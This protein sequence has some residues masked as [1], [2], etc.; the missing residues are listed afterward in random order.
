MHTRCIF[1]VRNRTISNQ[2]GDYTVKL[3]QNKIK[4]MVLIWFNIFWYYF[5]SNL[6]TSKRKWMK[7]NQWSKSYLTSSQTWN[8]TKEIKNLRKNIQ[9]LSKETKSNHDTLKVRLSPSKK[10]FFICFN[11][12][13]SK[14]MKNAVYFIL[15]ALFV[16]KIFEFLS[17]L[18]GHVEK[19]LD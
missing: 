11:D 3:K 9:T 19:W 17:W 12:S 6:N 16:L 4:N 5:T 14:I 8:I 1:R 2:N 15:K 7:T 10:K 13:L 18:F